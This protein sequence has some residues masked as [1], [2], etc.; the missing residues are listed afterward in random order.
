MNTERSGAESVNVDPDPPSSG[1]YRLKD[2]YFLTPFALVGFGLGVW[3]FFS[4]TSAAC[5]R[6]TFGAAIFR[7]L[8]LVIHVGANFSLG[9]D[10]LPLVIAQAVL[11]L[12]LIL[13]TIS[14]GARLVLLNLRH[15][16]QVALVRAMHGHVIVCGLGTTGTEAVRTLSAKA[17][18]VVAISL[19]PSGGGARVCERL[20]VPAI[21]GDAVSPKVLVAAGISRAH[22]VVMT[23]GSDARNME[24]CLS[25]ASLARLDW[26]DVRLF[27]EIRGAWLLETLAAQRT[28]VLGN[29]VQLHPFSVNEITARAMLCHPAFGNVASNPVLLFVGFEDLGM[30]ILRQ[31]LVSV[32]AIPGIRVRAMCCDAAAETQQSA[33]RGVPWRQLVDL[34]FFQHAFGATVASNWAEI[35]RHIEER[36]PNIVIVTLPDDDAAFQ[37]AIVIRNELDALLQFETPIFVRVRSQ[38]RLGELL[39]KIVAL[40]FCPYRLVSFGDLGRVVS[41]DALFDEQLDTM[42][43]A[44]HDAYLARSSGDSPARLPWQAL[45]ELYRRSNRAA[46]DHIHVKL[47]LGGYRMVNGQ[48]QLATL[49]ETAIDCMAR[50]EHYRW[51]LNLRAEGWTTGDVRSD[52]LKLHPLLVPWEELSETTKRDNREHIR[53]IPAALARVGLQLKRIMQV[54]PRGEISRDPSIL[55]LFVL[56]P[57][58]EKDWAAVEVF[59]RERDCIAT[60]RHDPNLRIETLTD[61]Q[62]KYPRVAGIITGWQ[63]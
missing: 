22:A 63:S 50:A 28:P 32:Y 58:D 11:P 3:G 13:G 48:E 31:A 49:D 36:P 26:Q 14:A 27:P 18:K 6:T 2:W 35:R 40:P 30:A 16:V 45:P 41:P 23:T 61:L 19:D 15:D 43:R 12:I 5:A 21:I 59:A 54:S 46:A 34:E 33:T 38:L 56:D 17:G 53:A 52:L 39:G 25:I 24:I 7:T 57:A 10:P 8:L 20:G 9:T 29:G 55:P 51:C 42:A 60:I 62:V 37:A 44:L 47:N 1:T 4:C